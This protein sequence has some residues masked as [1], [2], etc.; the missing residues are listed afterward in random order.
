MSPVAPME[1]PLQQYVTVEDASDDEYVPHVED[2][3]STR[4]ILSFAKEPD[5]LPL[6]IALRKP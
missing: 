2:A 6:G 5:V 4:L 1:P 3:A